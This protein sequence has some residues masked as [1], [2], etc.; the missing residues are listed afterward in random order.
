MQKFA[1][2]KNHR[3]RKICVVTGTRAEYGLLRPILYEIKN[4]KDLKLQL[5]VTGMHL[6]SSFGKTRDYILNDVF[7][8]NANI[9]MTPKGDSAYDMAGS[10]GTGILGMSKAFNKLQPDIVLVLGDRVEALSASIAAVY[11]GICVAHIHGGDSAEAGLDENAR[12]AIT[13]LAHIH[14]PATKKSAERIVK[15]GEDR[16]R[17]FITG[18][19]GLDDIEKKKFLSPKEISA[20]YELD[21]SK[22]VILVV[23]HP[24]TTEVR[25]ASKQIKETLE[26]VINLKLQTMILYPNSDAGGRTMIKLIESYSSKYPWVKTHKSIPRNNYLGLLN[27]ASVLVGNSSSG[28]IE[29]SS[30]YIPV[31]D[32][33]TRQKGRESSSNIINVGY[34]KNE[35]IRAINKAI[36]DKSFLAKVK[37]AKNPYS[38]KNTGLKIVRILS[39][40]NLD[41]RLLKKKITY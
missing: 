8:I 23:Q 36:R 21:L 5:L 39:T 30:F 18:A 1:M 29:S 7:T 4:N 11:S 3:K 17:V 2:K 25:D 31:V 32:I 34:N 6:S 15:M 37:V 35:I 38:A 40:V 22:P 20:K 24:V 13:K 12:H 27:V 10:I 28:I 33:G 14:F 9:P 16:S 41:S 19:P 26:A